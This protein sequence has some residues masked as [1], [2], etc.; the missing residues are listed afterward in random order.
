MIG[1]LKVGKF[2]KN[3]HRNDI[4]LQ[5]V[6]KDRSEKSSIGKLW[7]HNSRGEL[8]RLSDVVTIIEKPALL[9]ITRDNRQ[10][11]IRMFANVSPGK[12]QSDAMKACEDIGKKLLPEGYKLVFSGSAQSFKDSFSDLGLVM[13]LGIF[14]AYMVL[15]TQFNSFVHPFTVLLALP[16]SVS[17]AFMALALSGHSLNIYSAIGLILLMGLVKKNSILLVDFTNQRR[18]EGLTVKDALLNACPVRLRPILMTSVATVAAAV[19]PAVAVGLGAETRAP[20]AIVI[21]G[22]VTLSTLLTL[23]VVPCAYSLL[24][25]LEGRTHQAD[26]KAAMLELDAE[27]DA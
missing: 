26:V 20:M 10:R 18:A 23:F 3:G 11:A 27:A 13:I 7:V 4:R 2:T 19:P 22:G 14:V 25:G 15:G 17:G 8:V 24:S 1:G 16:F 12:S 6:A 21:I 9:S 5:L